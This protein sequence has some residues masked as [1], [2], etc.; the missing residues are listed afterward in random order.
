MSRFC[1]YRESFNPET[2]AVLEAA[3]TL[4][5]G[6]RSAMEAIC[7]AIPRNVVSTRFSACDLLKPW[8]ELGSG[9]PK[10]EKY[11]A[12]GAAHLLLHTNQNQ[13]VAADAYTPSSRALEIAA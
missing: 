7:Q 12:P 8:R 5:G 2:L 1:S 13:G 10:R 9:W 4:C 6:H 3:R 11:E